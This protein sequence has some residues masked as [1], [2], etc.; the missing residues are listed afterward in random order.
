MNSIPSKTQRTNTEFEP[1]THPWYIS[2]YL[3][4]DGIRVEELIRYEPQ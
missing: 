2:A 1:F 3:R 4:G